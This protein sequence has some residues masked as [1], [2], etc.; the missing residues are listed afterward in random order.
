MHRYRKR[1]VSFLFFW[2]IHVNANCVDQYEKSI[3][4]IVAFCKVYGYVRYFH[5]SDEAAQIDWDKF[6]ILGINAIKNIPEDQLINSFNALF[7]PIAPT[8]EFSIKPFP[9]NY[10]SPSIPLTN[11][12]NF[13]TT[14]WQ[15]FGVQGTDD[16]GPYKSRRTN[17]PPDAKLFSE[18][19]RIGDCIRD[20]LSRDLYCYVPLCLYCT[21]SATL[22]KSDVVKFGSLKKEL[23]TI[24]SN[25]TSFNNRI[26]SVILTWNLIQH[27]YPYRE[28]MDQWDESLRE[29]IIK[30]YTDKT[31]DDFMITLNMLLYHIND[32]HA[33]ATSE[34]SS[35]NYL[36]PINW[37][38]IH[39]T[40]I[41][42]EIF[43]T[44]LIKGLSVGDVVLTIDNELPSTL[45]ERKMKTKSA[46]TIRY[47]TFLTVFSILKGEQNSTIKLKIIN[48]KAEVK[49]VEINRSVNMTFYWKNYMSPNVEHKIIN[50]STIYVNFAKASMAAIDSLMPIIEKK[51]FIICDLRG[52]PNNNHAFLSHLL[53][54]DDTATSWFRIPEVIF[55]NY[56]SVTYNISG[57]KLRKLPPK[58]TA[59]AIFIID[60][61]VVSYGEAFMSIVE[62]YKLGVIVGDS[63]AGT[64]GN[65]NTVKMPFEHTVIKFTGMNATK[66]NGNNLV[67][68]GIIP[69]VVLKPSIQ[70]VILHKDELL[71]KAIEV[72]RDYSKYKH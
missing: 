57:W 62:N 44:T 69:H 23:S 5:P 13:K 46:S 28:Q 30:C 37:Q 63:T 45:V 14:S 32:G 39:D 4:N 8:V 26:A 58:L 3:N 15:H 64:N 65:K 41:I 19:T 36:P 25:D 61:E 31:V 49:Y 38:Y 55:P 42:S 47:R 67:G 10:T 40:L 12:E 60:Q 20:K 54:I 48:K 18:T 66:L 59:K 72:T 43:D 29:A 16:N 9:N 24:N 50:D 51:K 1:I 17:R 27:F 52:Y 70:G 35:P 34:A 21:D 2:T 53:P 22:P 7:N 68:V 6:A 33:F 11:T 56:K 71:D